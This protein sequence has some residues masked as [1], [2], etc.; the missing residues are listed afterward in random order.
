MMWPKM[1][2]RSPSEPS[3][4][5]CGLVLFPPGTSPGKKRR[6]ILFA[7]AYLAVAASLVWPIYPMFS[8]IH[9]LV[10]GLPLS[11]AWIVLALFVGFAAL[12]ALYLT[13]EDD[14]PSGAGRS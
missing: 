4:R 7:V 12:L 8:G 14:E 1:S 2:K 10:L 9:P 5:R 3:P 11:L 13:E 6:R